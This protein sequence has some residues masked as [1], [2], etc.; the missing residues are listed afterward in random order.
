MHRLRLLFLEALQVGRGPKR[1]LASKPY[2]TELSSEASREIDIR[3]IATRPLCF[4]L[5]RRA[6]K[7]KEG[8]A[9]QELFCI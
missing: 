4:L 9:C 7:E 3:L 6:L 5:G 2:I 8:P 1:S